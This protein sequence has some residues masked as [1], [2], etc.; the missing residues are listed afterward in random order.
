MKV[1]F[2]SNFLNRHQLP[3][4]RQLIELGVELSFVAL[5]D[6]EI[7]GRDN[8]NGEFDWVIR[9]YEGPNEEDSAMRHALED[10]IVLFGHLGGHEEY[11]EARHSI[12][13]PF[14]RETERILKQG[15]WWRLVPPKAFR[16]RKWFLQYQD[17]PMYVLCTGAY[18][19]TDLALS[20]F[21]I[22]KCLN[23]GYFVDLP[24]SLDRM[25]V[26]GEETMRLF[27]AGRFIGWKHPDYALRVARDLWGEGYKLKLKVAGVG[28][29][30]RRL[31]SYARKSG[32]CDSVEFAGALL[33]EE[34]YETMRCSDVYLFTSDRKEGWGAAL[35]EAMS[36]G[37]A[38]IAGDTAGATRMLIEDGV[39]GLIYREDD[40]TQFLSCVRR[41][42]DDRALAARLG[43]A[44]RRGVVRKA[45]P[46]LAVRNFLCVCR[47]LLG[48]GD[49]LPSCGPCSPASLQS[50]G[51]RSIYGL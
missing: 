7:I 12:G 41:C 6:E 31:V 46:E 1:A 33:P 4:C 37:C 38:V 8:L 18:A 15:D 47:R 11:V 10:D 50:A 5:S 21:P 3:F 26:G 27:W 36:C 35:G 32:I 40:Y 25:P 51:S 34:V 9:A 39:D 28:A 49:A 24:S 45:S 30:E 48:N 42:F 29:M 20:G 2:F 16:T 13:K 19:A 43:A 22:E 44:A 14:L 17:D 23:W